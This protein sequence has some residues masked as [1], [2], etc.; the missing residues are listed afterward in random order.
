VYSVLRDGEIT[1]ANTSF[2][3]L[4]GYKREEMIGKDIRE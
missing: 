4:F 3:E 1:D 2:C